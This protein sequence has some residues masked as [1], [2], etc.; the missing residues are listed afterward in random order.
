MCR[1]SIRPRIMKLT[2][3]NL[4]VSEIKISAKISIC[5]NFAHKDILRV[6]TSF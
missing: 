3:L 5:L 1:Q 2:H 4:A 6:I